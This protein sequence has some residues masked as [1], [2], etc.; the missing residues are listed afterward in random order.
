MF[1]KIDSQ[2]RAISAVV[3]LFA[4]LCTVIVLPAYAG[5]SSNPDS[6]ASNGSPADAS[7]LQCKMKGT[8]ESVELLDGSKENGKFEV[9]ILADG[10]I[11]GSYSGLLSG[12]IS[13]RVDSRG[14]FQAEGRGSGP[15][16]SWTGRIKKSETEILGSGE[17]TASV[18]SGVW[19]G[20]SY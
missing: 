2:N 5:T 20:T 9:K 17:W 12:I 14:N 8:W 13:G 15:D 16:V 7:E 4:L 11:T 6:P 1:V 19:S 10:T 18:G 3:V